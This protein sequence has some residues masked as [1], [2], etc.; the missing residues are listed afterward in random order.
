MSKKINDGGPAFPTEPRG[1]AYGVA[2]N[3][4]TLRDWLAGQALAGLMAGYYANP[5]SGGLGSEEIARLVYR[6]ANA[7]LEARK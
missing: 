4:M 2:Y 6:Q 5:N 7:M 3:G 1:P